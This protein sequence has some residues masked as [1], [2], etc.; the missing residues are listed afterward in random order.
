MRQ[1]EAERIKAESEASTHLTEDMRGLVSRVLKVFFLVGFLRLHGV[2]RVCFYRVCRGLL[3]EL[4]R[5][6]LVFRFCQGSMYAASGFYKGFSQGIYKVES[7]FEFGYKGFGLLY[8]LME[9]YCYNCSLYSYYTCDIP[10]MTI[11]IASN[12]VRIEASRGF[13][14]GLNN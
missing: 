14:R 5:A 1:A 10:I 3:N 11:M 6:L 7:V 8:G 12:E 9:H 13:H 2:R 4:C